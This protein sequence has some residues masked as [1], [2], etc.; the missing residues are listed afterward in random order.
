MSAVVRNVLR[1][2]PSHVWSMPTR[3]NYTGIRAFRA[4]QFFRDWS[5]RLCYR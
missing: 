2:A 1:G 4:G 5:V 3:H